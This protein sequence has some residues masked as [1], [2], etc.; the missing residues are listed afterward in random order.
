MDTFNF[1]FFDD[2]KTPEPQDSTKPAPKPVLGFADEDD[3][4][5]PP[6]NGEDFDFALDLPSTEP[7]NTAPADPL[8]FD[9]DAP[10]MAPQSSSDAPQNA[11][12]VAPTEE[13]SFGDDADSLGWS[14]GE[15]VAE[16]HDP[17]GM[18]LSLDAPEIENINAPDVAEI[19][20]SAPSNSSAIAPETDFSA[21]TAEFSDSQEI[22]STPQIETSAPQSDFSTPAIDPAPESDSFAS[23]AKISAPETDFVP[24]AVFSDPKTDF[25]DPEIDFSVQNDKLAPSDELILDAPDVADTIPDSFVAPASA[26]LDLEAPAIDD[27]ELE[28]MDSDDAIAPA[29]ARDPF[30]DYEPPPPPL[31][32]AVLGASGVGKTHARW[33]ARHG[34]EVVAFLG[35]TN[36]SVVATEESLRALFDFSGQGFNN[37]EKLLDETQPEAVCV[38]TPPQFHFAQVQACLERGIHVL[39]EKPLVY[40]PGRPMRE[41]LTAARDLVKLADKKGLVFGTQLQYG[42][43][44]PILCKLAGTTFYDVGDF[45]MEMET[46][47]P[48]ASRD[49]KELWIDLA[50]HPISIAQFLG[51]EGAQLLEESVQVV[52]Q[53]SENSTALSARFGIQC[54][55]GRLLVARAI[56]RTLDRHRENREPRRRFS[57]NG[58][59]VQYRRTRDHRAQYTAPDDYDSLYDDP[60]DYL[61]GNFTRACRGKE[62][63][64]ISGEFGRQNLEWLLKIGASL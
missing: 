51:G 11:P 53:V 48:R 36:T 45:A 12:V 41:S 10:A 34:C 26:Q 19:D 27:A 13:F 43:A 31:K 52:A 5:A 14:A 22:L 30:E 4:P 42:A 9:L 32:V 35:S 38:S 24:P 2:D 62:D 59:V 15:V 54:G 7:Q 57:F 64:L 29:R 16:E 20:F 61:L 37:L 55:D 60:V 6:S 49:P 8:D 44:T 28:E 23:T 56:L 58:R 46:A 63:L 1:S 25:S 18:E 39:C 17:L 3:A 33:F 47:N 50:P 21:S 40:A